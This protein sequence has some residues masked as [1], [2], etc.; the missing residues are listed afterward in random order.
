MVNFLTITPMITITSMVIITMVIMVGHT[1][2]QVVCHWLLTV[3]AQVQSQ[4]RS[5]SICG[6]QSSS[7]ASILQVLWFL[8]P[9]LIPPTITRSLIILS[10]WLYNLRT[11]I[12]K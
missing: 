11:D 5:C 2:A 3:A 12:I 9:I 7:E 4:V 1:V 8:V 6:G 10:S